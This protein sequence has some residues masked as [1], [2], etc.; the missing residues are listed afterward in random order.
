[1]SRLQTLQFVPLAVGGYEFVAMDIEDDNGDPENP[2]QVCTIVKKFNSAREVLVQLEAWRR[3]VDF[4]GKVYW[5]IW[6]ERL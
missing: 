3:Q 4:D 6:R 5:E 1:M 2:P